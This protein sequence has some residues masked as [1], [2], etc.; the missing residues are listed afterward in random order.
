MKLWF[1]H[2]FRNIAWLFHTNF[3]R[4][5]DPA[6][7]PD[8]TVNLI[9]RTRGYATWP[10]C[11]ALTVLTCWVSNCDIFIATLHVFQFI[12]EWSVTPSRRDTIHMFQHKERILQQSCLSQT[13]HL[14][15]KRDMIFKYN[16]YNFY[17]GLLLG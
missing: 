10:V 2:F 16:F 5:V 14:C 9:W 8:L 13:S 4:A 12:S 15:K 7:L 3:A 11:S 1:A 6:I 17:P